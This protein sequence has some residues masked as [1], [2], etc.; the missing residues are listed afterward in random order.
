MSKFTFDIAHLRKYINGELSPREMHEI[1]RAAHEDEMLMD[2]LMGLEIEKEN[3]K[4]QQPPDDIRQLIAKRIKQRSAVTKPLWN[5]RALKIVASVILLVTATGVFIWNRQNENTNKEAA[6]VSYKTE[7][8]TGPSHD[9]IAEIATAPDSANKIFSDESPT[10]QRINAENLRKHENNRSSIGS[11]TQNKH[12]KPLLAYTPTEKNIELN[13]DMVG[14]LNLGHPKHE[15]DVIIINTEAQD[16]SNLLASNQKK[17]IQPKI[18]DTRISVNPNSP[19]SSA[20]MRA[21]ISSMGLDPQANFILGQVLDQQSKQPL[22]GAEVTDTQNDKVVLTDSE[23]RFAYAANS[24]KSLKVNAVGYTAREVTA[25]SGEQTILLSPKDD[26]LNETS[27]NNSIQSEKSTPIT[28][29]EKY[30]TYLRSEMAKITDR[31]YQ[32]TA[33]I[34]LS[35]KGIPINISIVKSSEKALNPKVIQ[36]LERGPVWKRGTDWKNISL[37]I[38]S[39]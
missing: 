4:S 35:N 7:E 32:F 36:L 25:E 21:R 2:I 26:L 14:T 11:S 3:N 10:P 20:Q 13:Q 17:Q 38:N 16:N 28:G 5:N 18:T 19:P 8:F 30:R 23:G 31:E 29:W 34:E 27:I 24:K 39:L 6:I 37:Q 22:A 9:R 33:Q 1:E 15:S 12:E